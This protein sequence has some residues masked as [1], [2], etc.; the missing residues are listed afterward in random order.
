[1]MTLK[2]CRLVQPLNYISTVVAIQ[3]QEIH[4][5]NQNLNAS[6]SRLN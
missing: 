4:A 5:D 2:S 1:M 6:L 3:G